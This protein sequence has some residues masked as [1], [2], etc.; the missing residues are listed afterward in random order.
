MKE[1]DG[2]I[3]YQCQWTKAPALATSLCQPLLSAREQVYLKGYIGVDEQGV[4]FGNISQRTRQP[5]QFIIT[6]SQTGAL[7]KLSCEHIAKVTDFDLGKN[8]LWCHGPIKASSEAMSHGAL[9][10]A[11][12]WVEWVIHIH[13]Q[14][15]WQRFIHH[16]PTTSVRAGYGSPALAQEIGHLA[17]RASSRTP[18]VMVLAGHEP[19]L[20][21]YGPDLTSTL[22]CLGNLAL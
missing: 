22:N 3:K 15:L 9:Y 21:I 1:T 16:Y 10:Q 14:D 11:A 7:A 12:P 5:R 20:I 13:D 2:I 19:G 18:Q 4:G 17:A 8:E 6:G